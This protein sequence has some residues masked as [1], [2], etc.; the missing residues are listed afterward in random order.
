[1]SERVTHTLFRFIHKIA[2]MDLGFQKGVS[3]TFLT[4]GVAS[5]IIFLNLLVFYAV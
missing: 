2:G 5:Q 3:F 1:M 4:V